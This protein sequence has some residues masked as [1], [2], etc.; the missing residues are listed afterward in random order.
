MYKR[1]HNSK[2]SDNGNQKKKNWQNFLIMPKGQNQ[3]WLIFST[4][5]GVPLREQDKPEEETG[6][7]EQRKIRGKVTGKECR[8]QNSKYILISDSSRNIQY[9]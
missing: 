6:L 2:K 9:D 4:W 8:G 5:M 7:L 3:R 1:R